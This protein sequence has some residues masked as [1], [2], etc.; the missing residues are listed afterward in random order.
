MRVK[1]LSV[2]S[3][4]GGRTAHKSVDLV[5]LCVVRR[6]AA[7]VDVGAGLGSSEAGLLA[8]GGRHRSTDLR[9]LRCW[10]IARSVTLIFRVCDVNFFVHVINRIAYMLSFKT[11]PAAMN[12]I[13]N[14]HGAVSARTGGGGGG[15]TRELISVD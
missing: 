5:V 10:Q 7:R 1:A 2:R 12:T 3:G 11:V 13:D 8:G 14:A 9:L 6:P 15:R 4:L